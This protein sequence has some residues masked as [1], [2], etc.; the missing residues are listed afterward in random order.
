MEH[1]DMIIIG[2]GPIGLS[3]GIECSRNGVSYLIIDKGP[4]VNSLFHY[5]L[6]MTFFSTSD[7]LE[8]GE[9]PFIS[10]NP[11]P[12]RNEALEYYRRVSLHWKLR[13]SLYDRVVSINKMDS[14]FSVTT[15]KG[16][17]RSKAVV[18]ATGF[19]DIPNLMNVSGEHLPKVHHFYKE[20]HPFFGQKIVVVGAANSA[21]DVAL[22]TWRKGAEVT[23][24]IRDAGIRESVKYWVRPEI[25]NRI[26]NG[27]IRA[28]FES[29]LTNISEHEVEIL[30]PLGMVS[31]DN[32]QVLAMTGYLPDFDFLTATGIRLAH[33]AMKTP[34]H[35]PETMETNVKGIYLAG[36]ICGGLKTNKWFIE[37]SRLHA[38]SIVRHFLS[39]LN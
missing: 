33:D 35:D 32:D 34:M 30:T 12:T 19:Y 39:S 7:K 16:A 21:V 31:I 22:E 1:L 27:E 6:N 11:K 23:M 24:V 3:C 28:F 29:T 36:V 5:P 20:A 15:S 14:F 2:A 10:N 37:N 9:V 25:E 18:I 4:L 17:Y 13:L 38:Q 26:Q 8:I